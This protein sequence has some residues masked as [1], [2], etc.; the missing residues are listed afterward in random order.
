MRL[1]SKLEIG[2]PIPLG[3]IA[4][5]FVAIFLIIVNNII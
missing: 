5:T 3:P 1:S 2:G 4:F